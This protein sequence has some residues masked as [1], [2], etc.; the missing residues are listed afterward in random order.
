MSNDNPIDK[1]DEEPGTTFSVLHY[2]GDGFDRLWS[3]GTD[4]VE[5]WRQDSP[6]GQFEMIYRVVESW[7]ARCYLLGSLFSHK[8][9]SD[10]KGT[11]RN[12]G[13]FG[14]LVC[15]AIQAW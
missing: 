6:C 7:I 10:K 8:Q 15:R 1:A 5:Q 3:Q 9:S 13:T 2:G 11:F 12:P 14:C 4:V